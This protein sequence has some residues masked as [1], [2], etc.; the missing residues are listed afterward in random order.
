MKTAL[1]IAAFILV[2]FLYA[3]DSMPSVIKAVLAFV[4]WV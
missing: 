4:G 3:T 2:A 1:A